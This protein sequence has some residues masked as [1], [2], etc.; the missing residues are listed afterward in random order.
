MKSV[1]S[2]R[3]FLVVLVAVLLLFAAA[4]PAVLASL[5]AGHGQVAGD[6]VLADGRALADLL[7]QLLD[8]GDDLGGISR[9]RKTNVHLAA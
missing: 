9:S 5:A 4:Y 6:E 1:I 2:S 7:R 3:R 8:K